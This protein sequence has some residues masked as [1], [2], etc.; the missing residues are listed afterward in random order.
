MN[1]KQA[2]KE[3]RLINLMITTSYKKQQ[4]TFNVWHKGCIGISLN[5]RRRNN[6]Q[7]TNNIRRSKM[8]TVTETILSGSYKVIHMDNGEIE[9]FKIPIELI[10]Q[11]KLGLS[12]EKQLMA[13]IRLRANKRRLKPL[14]TITEPL[15]IE[16][17]RISNTLLWRRVV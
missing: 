3:L 10:T 9:I 11:V 14:R 4:E 13:M 8:A 12:K 15:K 17:K 16:F 5:D 2:T 7:Q 1:R 6:P